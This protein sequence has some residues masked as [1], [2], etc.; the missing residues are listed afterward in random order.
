[1]PRER[2]VCQ[3][4]EWC[5]C[6]GHHLSV[7]RRAFG[8]VRARRFELVD[9]KERPWATLGFD[10]HGEVHFNLLNRDGRGEILL[11]F[12]EDEPEIVLFAAGNTRARVAVT[13][14]EV[15]LE[16]LDKHASGVL[17]LNIDED[18]KPHIL[19]R[20]RHD[21]WADLCAERGV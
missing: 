13:H 1:M 18:G 16:M 19:T 8:V 14:G 7:P 10:E 17:K 15:E 12:T 9:A 11:A 5:P 20:I 21:E 2:A 3:S 4:T 6:C